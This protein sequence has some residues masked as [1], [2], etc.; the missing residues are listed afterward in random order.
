MK[1]MWRISGVD[2]HGGHERSEVLSAWN[3][4]DAVDAANKLGLL[5][6][7]WVQLPTRRRSVYETIF[8]VAKVL[9]LLVA[10]AVLSAGLSLH[11]SAIQECVVL[12]AV[13]GILIFARIMQA[14]EHSRRDSR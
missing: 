7:S 10:L 11:N 13:C 6:S 1:P 8:A 14:E 12:T 5:P 3:A 9:A 4:G 2:K